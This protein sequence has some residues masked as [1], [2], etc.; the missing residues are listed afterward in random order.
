VL[1]AG[2][3]PFKTETAAVYIFGRAT[4]YPAGAASLS[5]ALL[6]I[7]FAVL[8]SVGGLRRLVTK[9]DR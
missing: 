2:N 4:D 6:L 9:H 7:S 8:L 5:L 3:I 1:I